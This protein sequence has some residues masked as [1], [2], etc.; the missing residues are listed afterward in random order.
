MKDRVGESISRLSS[1][2]AVAASVLIG[3][4]RPRD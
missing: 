3:E 2:P 4:L 1:K